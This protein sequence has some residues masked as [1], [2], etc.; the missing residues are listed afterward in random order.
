[1]Q[2]VQLRRLKHLMSVFVFYCRDH[3]NIFDDAILIIFFCAILPLRIVVW[4]LPWEELETNDIFL[5]VAGHLYGFNTMLLTLRAFGSLLDAFEG[6]GT[7]QIALFNIFRDAAVIV[8]HLS[9]IAFAF[10]TTLT[11]V[12]LSDKKDGDQESEFHT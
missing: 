4:V 10:S 5:K 8:V 7:I 6:V 1:M 12:F 9:M 2:S 11:K 3:W